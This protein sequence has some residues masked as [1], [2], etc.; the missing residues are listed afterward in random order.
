MNQSI[1]KQAPLRLESGEYEAL[2][3][4][5]L[6]RDNWR[7]QLCGSMQNLE[8]HHQLFRSHSG[9][10]VEGNLITLCAKCHIRIHEVRQY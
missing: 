5:V 3:L 9:A 6:R 7:C 10:D 8:V 2:R 1:H 4:Q